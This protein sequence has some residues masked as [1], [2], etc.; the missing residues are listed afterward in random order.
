MHTQLVVLG[1]GPGGYAAAFL[2][3]DEGMEVVIVEAD[4]RLGGT[5]LL[6]GCI[7][8]KALLHVAR[9]MS[10]VDELSADWGVEYGKPKITLDALRARKEKVI[11]NLT[12]GLAQLAK[13]RKVNVIQA[14]G[15]FVNSTTLQLEG[16]RWIKAIEYRACLKALHDLLIFR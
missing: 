13:R 9:V 5:C 14:R 10:E 4:P 7:P 12:G 8:S 11:S 1:G 3:A 2:A 15:S 16:D 6:R